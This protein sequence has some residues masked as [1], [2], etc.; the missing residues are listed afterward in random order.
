MPKILGIDTSNYTTSIAVVDM[1][2]LVYENRVLLNVKKGERGLRQ[3][4]A[5]FQHIKTLPVLLNNPFVKGI[6]GVCV[7]TRPRPVEGS[8]MPVFKAGESIAEAIAYTNGIPIF[9]TSHQEGHIEAAVTSIDFPDD[10]F[11]AIHI[12]GGTTEVLH[13]NRNEKYSI[14]IIGGTRDI[15]M[16]QLIDR[17]GVKLGFNFPAGRFIDKLAMEPQK[18]EIRIPS[19][20]DGLFF[21][22]SGQETQGLRYIEKGNTQEEIAYA[23]MLCIGKT[24]EK[25]FNNI[26]KVWNLPIILMGGV[27]SSKFLKNYFNDK[28]NSYVYLADG[29]YASDNAVGIAYIGKR[30]YCK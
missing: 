8:Y 21:N 9:K 14:E 7:S 2:K 3:S 11:I 5:L 28:Y 27:A 16:G 19:K 25:L 15:S 23:V 17:I 12:S 6:D 1:D 18:T 30:N 29:R 20:V 24:L 13:V 26:L 10:E 22:L 4:E